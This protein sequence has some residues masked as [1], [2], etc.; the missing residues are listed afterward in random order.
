MIF[1]DTETCGFHGVPVLIQWAED[2]GQIHLH[3]IWR[4][5]CKDTLSLIQYIMD[6]E[7]C[8]FNLAFDIFH[9][10]KIYNMLRL[11]SPREKPEDIVDELVKIEKQARDGVCCKPKRS[12]DL[13][14]HA[15][16]GKYQS[17][18]DRKDIRIRKIPNILAYHLADYLET[19]ITFDEIYFARRKKKG[20][21]WQVFDR[22][23]KEGEIVDPD[24]KDVVCK[25][26]PSSALKTLAAEVLGRPDLVKFGDVMVDDWAKP[27][28]YGYAPFAQA[29]YDR[30]LKKL[31]WPTFIHEHK[32]HWGLSKPQKYAIQDVE[33]TR[34]LYYAFGSPEPGDIDSEL[35]SMVGAVR[36]KGFEIDEKKIRHLKSKINVNKFIIAPSKANKYITSVMDDMDKTIFQQ[37]GGGTDKATLKII[38]DW[39]LDCECEPHPAA[40][41][42]KEVADARSLDYKE[43]VFD[44]LLL[45]DRFHASFK[46]IGTLTSRMSGTDDLNAHGIDKT[47]EVRECFPLGDS[48]CGGDFSSFE[49]AI[50]DACCEDEKIHQMLISG[51]SVHGIFG[52]HIYKDMDYDEICATKGMEEDL[53]GRSKTG[54]FAVLYGGE[55]FTLSTRLNISKERGDEAFLSFLRDHPGVMKKRKEANYDYCPISQPKGIG[56]EVLWHDPKL[57]SESLLGFRRYFDLEYRVCKTLF[58]IAQNPPKQWQ[59]L[60]IKCQRSDR[61]QSVSGAVQSA[62]YGAA[63]GVQG[64]A[65]RAAI[66]HEI[67]ST[68]AGI[69]KDVE[70]R[71]WRVQP[72]GCNSWVVRPMQVHDEI[73]AV[74]DPAATQQVANVVRNRVEELKD[75]V[76]LL[77]LDWSV[78]GKNWADIH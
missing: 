62:L 1:L 37:L 57:Y 34:D 5:E 55:G 13:M 17:T 40:V 30:P 47:D 18:M 23:N 63:F 74:V 56:T 72:I 6:Q 8:G 71:I 28:E 24:F 78:G 38:A 68:G 49:V 10:N 66:N 26:A 21:H 32:L 52:T 73:M 42:A 12:L 31:P 27:G 65:S 70:E 77:K 35:A 53:Y 69:T 50:F 44:K 29:V 20:P 46:I 3:E 15:R 51:K 76:P 25:F 22:K 41:R 45:A 14:L 59:S 39:K 75:T 58:N 67:Q 2:G 48:L 19:E 11:V 36:W 54:F 33:I 64:S 4:E 60:K 9:I 16:K 61:I 7:V 43:K